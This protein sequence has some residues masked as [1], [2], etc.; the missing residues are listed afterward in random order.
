MRTELISE[1]HSLLQKNI[2]YIPSHEKML[3]YCKPKMNKRR[4]SKE[5]IP[6]VN[7]EM[8]DIIFSLRQQIIMST[9]Q[10]S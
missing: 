2:K 1:I 10:C 9:L 8:K 4:L 5:I 7:N 3:R 6:L